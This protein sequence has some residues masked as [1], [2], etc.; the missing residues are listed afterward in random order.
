MQQL[1]EI[2]IFCKNT[3]NLMQKNNLTP[4]QMMQIMKIG[5]TSFEKLQKGVLSNRITVETLFIL[6]QRFN[7]TPQ[8][9]FSDIL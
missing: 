6:C 2:D 3:I 7:V 8:K 1:T 4:K 5:K 9:M